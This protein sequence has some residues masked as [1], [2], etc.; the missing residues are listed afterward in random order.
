MSDFPI[1][2]GQPVVA[3]PSN[4]V[5]Y[6]AIFLALIAIILVIIIIFV[7]L[8]SSNVLNEVVD[9]WVLFVSY[10]GE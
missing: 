6:F 9:R 5:A 7:A 10:T 1:Y 8:G 4:A 2:S 3:A